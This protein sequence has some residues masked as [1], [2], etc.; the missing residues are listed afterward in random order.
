LALLAAAIVSLVFAAHYRRSSQELADLNESL[1]NSN[2]QLGEANKSLEGSNLAL[3]QERDL[4]AKFTRLLR[5]T[6]GSTLALLGVAQRKDVLAN[7]RLGAVTVKLWKE[8]LEDDPKDAFARNELA[9]ALY[10]QGVLFRNSGNA[11]EQRR[12]WQES[13]AVSEALVKDKPDVLD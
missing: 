6:S 2:A 7:Q 8:F 9:N 5:A 12:C 3:T 4:V 10:Y 11:K 13:A 1:A